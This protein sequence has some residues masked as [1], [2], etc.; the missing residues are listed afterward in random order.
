MLWG[1]NQL[2]EK[3]SAIDFFG[4]DVYHPDPKKRNHLNVSGNG[5]DKFESRWRRGSQVMKQ[6]QIIYKGTYT[7]RQSIANQHNTFLIE[8]GH[9][10]VTSLNCQFA[11][12]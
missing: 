2:G 8:M 4:I 10:N 7:A 12:K 9:K 6:K 5:S 3:I 11:Y 1:K